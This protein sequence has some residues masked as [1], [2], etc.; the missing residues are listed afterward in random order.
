MNYSEVKNVCVHFRGFLQAHISYLDDSCQ[1]C[2]LLLSVDR[3]SFFALSECKNRIREVSE[4]IF[5]ILV[6][7]SLR[8]SKSV[9]I[10]FI[11]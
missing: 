4:A 11:I 5:F 9:V 7:E 8:F 1:T 3:D 2:L 6:Q 10:I